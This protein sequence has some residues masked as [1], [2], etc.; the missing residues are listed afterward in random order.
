MEKI[1]I[2]IPHIAQ[3][4]HLLKLNLPLIKKNL[5]PQ[6]VYIAAAQ[7]ALDDLS[8]LK[9]KTVALI[10][11]DSILPG[12]SFKTTQ[13][14]MEK[15]GLPVERTG[16][17][18][19]QFL[20]LGWALKDEDSPWYLSWDSDTIPVRPVSFFSDTGKPL[21]IKKTEFNPAYFETIEK[22]LGLKKN[23]DFSFIAEAMLFNKDFVKSM[24]NT[25]ENNSAVQGNVFYEKILYAAAQ[26]S[27][28]QSAFSEFE[29]YGTYVSACFPGSYE[30]KSSNGF[31]NGAKYVGLNPSSYDLQRFARKYDIVSF[32]RWNTIFKPFILL[33][34]IYS[35]IY[36][37][38]NKL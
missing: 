27:F 19:Q 29:T 26:S 36:V 5:N 7:P 34:K 24:I 12:L 30:F 21:F 18:F 31:R 35:F 38:I 1:S 33:Q 11:E 15:A 2:F 13:K 14:L 8:F 16:W 25:I 22:T 10:D 32:E 28:V 37:K 20:K 23:N 3:N 9:D 6:K 4:N 17:Y